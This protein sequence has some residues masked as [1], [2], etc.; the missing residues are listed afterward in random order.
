MKSI[1][2]LSSIAILLAS[3][4]FASSK[5]DPFSGKEVAPDEPPRYPLPT[6]TGFWYFGQ[7]QEYEVTAL[8]ATI[9]GFPVPGVGAGAIT[10]VKN[11][12]DQFNFKCDHWVFPWLNV[13]GIVGDATGEAVA[14]VSPLLGLPVGAFTVDYDALVYGGGATFVV[15]NESLFFSFTAD[16]TWGD[17]EFE[18]GPGLTLNDPSAIETLIL[19]PKIGYHGNRG[20]VWVGAYYQHTEHTQTGT[21]FLPLRGPVD[22]TADVEDKT[23]WTPVV[24]GEYFFNEHWSITGEFGFGEDR[25]QGLVGVTYRF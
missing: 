8:T 21:F 14:G 20:A 23:P 25:K 12:V 1:I 16:Y 17:V 15:G 11:R 22:F 9:G 13:H 19:T 4:P 2:T 10:R 5:D 18:T 3:G 24:G 6:G 7:E